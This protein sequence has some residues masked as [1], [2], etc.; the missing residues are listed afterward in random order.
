[1]VIKTFQGHLALLKVQF[2]FEKVIGPMT[3]RVKIPAHLDE[4]KLDFKA[5]MLL[6]WNHHWFAT[7]SL[8]FGLL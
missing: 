3:N 4:S 7:M 5:T 1:M 6:F 8:H 2:C